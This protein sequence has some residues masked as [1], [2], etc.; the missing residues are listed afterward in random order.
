MHALKRALVAAAAPL[1]AVQATALPGDVLMATSAPV[2]PSLLSIDPTNGGVLGNVPITN[3]EALFGGLTF[4]GSALYSIDGYNDGLPDRSFRIDPATGTGAV[5]G[6]TGLNWNFRS[7]EIHPQSGVLYATTDNR[8][9][10]LD[11]TTGA[12]GPVA[13]ITGATLDQATALAIDAT[14]K[15]YMTDIGG[16]GLFTLDLASGVLTHLGNLALAPS[17]WFQDLA[18]DSAGT[19]W[20]VWWTGGLYTIDTATPSA[21]LKL[22]SGSYG[23][24]AFR[25]DTQVTTYCTSKAG[26][27]CGTPSIRFSGCSSASASAGFSISAGPARAA[28][29]GILIHSDQGPASL[30]F[31]GGVLCVNP[32]LRRSAAVDS[33]GTAG[34]CDGVF[35]LDMNCFAAGA[36]GGN[37]ASFLSS[38]GTHVSTQW[39]GRDSVATG[40]FLSDGLTYVVGP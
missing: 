6:D 31:Q 40:S 36:C 19:L 9:Y 8:L 35:T 24:I 39:W 17:G 20:G 25:C 22:A 37:P 1:L 29:S 34:L 14:G 21:T 4:D 18:F 32:P 28:K 3:E 23:G 5:I 26:L 10:V 2:N 12:A 7:V 33:G 11:K 15:A 30:P 38:P 13:N 16:Q 27:A